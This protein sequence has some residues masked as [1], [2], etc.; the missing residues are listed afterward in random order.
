M[1]AAI[2]QL[3][4]PSKQRL[5]R[6][7]AAC[8]AIAEA[9]AVDELR[10]IEDHACLLQ[11]AA[12]IAK[13]VEAQ[14][15]W[16]EVRLRAERRL[17]ELIKA[18][19]TTTGKAGGRPRKTSSSEELVFKPALSDAG[20]DRKLSARAQ[21]IADLPSETFQDYVDG[22]HEKKRPLSPQELLRHSRGVAREQRFAEDRRLAREVNGR[23]EI[24]HCAIEDVTEE[25]LPDASVDAV[26]TDPPYPQKYLPSYS[27]LAEFSA[28]VL[29]PGGWCI[30]MTGTGFL[31]EVMQ[32]MC[33]H[34]EYRWQYVIITPG[35]ANNRNS[36]YGLFQAYKPVLIFQNPP[37]SRIREW[38]SD[39]ITAKADEQ[40]KSL[41]PWQQ[42]E[43]VFVELVDRF[44]RPGDVVVDPFAGSGTTGRAAVSI[45]RHFWGCDIDEKCATVTKTGNIEE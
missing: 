1:N 23:F 18:Q 3:V 33:E 19:W 8:Q 22:C 14:V 45:G 7:D 31:P 29:R 39:V 20:I 34:L 16:S 11:E 6:Y 40:D 5:L 32:R 12:R 26:I 36:A 44:S 21:K 27:T 4:S 2:I 30:V 13:N 28:R 35:G 43:K 9:F 15:Q 25:M 37:V 38:W 17:G 10:D 24:A 42:S 41:H